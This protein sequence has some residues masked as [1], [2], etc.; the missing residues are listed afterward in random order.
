MKKSSKLQYISEMQSMQKCSKQLKIT[1]LL[2]VQQK[3]DDWKAFH[4]AI[5][6]GDREKNLA[7]GQH[8]VTI[9]NE[10]ILIVL[11]VLKLYWFWVLKLQI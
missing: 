10:F 6:V 7:I 9:I 4:G 1:Y 2:V 5:E 3:D 8:W 11:P